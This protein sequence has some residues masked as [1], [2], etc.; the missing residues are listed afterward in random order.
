MGQVNW[1][2]G[3]MFVALFLV[4][5]L[6]LLDKEAKV[7]PIPLAQPVMSDDAEIS[8]GV[9]VGSSGSALATAAFGLSALQPET[10]N[11]EMVLDI[12]EASPLEYSE[13]DRLTAKLMAAKAGNA[14]LPRVLEDI[15]TSLAVE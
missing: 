3:S 7:R 14:Q 5:A 1:I 8:R 11:G 2:S 9:H 4:C 15:R 6:F 10:F 12:I 13:K